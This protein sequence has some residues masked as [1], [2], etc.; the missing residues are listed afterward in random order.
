M[1]LIRCDSGQRCNDT[2]GMPMPHIL[3]ISLCQGIEERS[4]LLHYD[5][6]KMI[7]MKYIINRCELVKSKCP[8]G[9]IHWALILIQFW[10]FHTGLTQVIHDLILW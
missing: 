5:L 9:I 7:K 1:G 4:G 6:L 3:L 10:R 8:G 2:F